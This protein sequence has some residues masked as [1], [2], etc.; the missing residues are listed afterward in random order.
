MLARLLTKDTEV[1]TKLKDELTFK[2]RN[3]HLAIPP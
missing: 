2:F 3:K 1:S